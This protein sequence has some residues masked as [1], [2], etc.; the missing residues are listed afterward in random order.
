MS[1][2]EKA[3]WF[4][5]HQQDWIP[6]FLKQ[7]QLEGIFYIS[8]FINSNRK[9]LTLFSQWQKKIKTKEFV[10]LGSGSGNLIKYIFL[11]MA[12]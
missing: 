1:S 5:S 6:N 2:K 9:F 8:A 3:L 4:E 7:I 12:L 11:Q 10:D